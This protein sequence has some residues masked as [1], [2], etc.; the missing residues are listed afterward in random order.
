MTASDYLVGIG[1]LAIFAALALT[2]ILVGRRKLYGP[3]KSRIDRMVQEALTDPAYA[4]Y[5][6]DGLDRID[7][8]AR[9][10]MHQPCDAWPCPHIGIHRLHCRCGQPW[11][12][13]LAG[14]LNTNPGAPIPG[15][16]DNRNEKDRWPL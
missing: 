12:C 2:V 15:Q 13:D 11:V 9:A 3:A 1:G 14:P 4:P 10:Q 16:R 8:V 6:P 7:H 5:G